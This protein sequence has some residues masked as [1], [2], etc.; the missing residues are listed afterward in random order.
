MIISRT[1]F[2]I[3]F[4]GGGTDYPKWYK[5][6]GGAV[7]A[8]TIDKYCYITCRYLPPFFEH[9]SRIIYSKMEYV[10]DIDEIQH[11]SVRATLKFM[12][13]NRGIEIH[14]DGDLPAR[15]GLGSSSAFT[16]GLL[17]ALYALKGFMPSKMQLAKEAIYIEQKILKE[18]VGVQDQT[19][20]A[21]GGFNRIEFGGDNHM[22]CRKVTIGNERLKLLENNLMLFFTGFTRTA[23][24]IAAEQIKNMPHKKRELKTIHQM[25]DEAISILNGNNDLSTFGNLL[26]ESWKLKR[27]LS[28]KVSMPYIDDIYNT[29]L[30]SGA[31][32]GKLLG[33]G[34]GGFILFFAKPENQSKIRKKLKHLLYVPFRFENLGSQIIFY[35]PDTYFDK[36]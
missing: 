19:L 22:H 20:A 14:H 32:G 24:E 27:S 25:V 31:I 18:N 29:A 11:P 26:N 21:I 8:T 10:K 36:K 4:F 34:G 3:S 17:N 16:V 1:P 28:S 9:K 5:E 7:L 23:S 13:I 35:E 2:R 6:H 15:T 12:D 33:A 30:K